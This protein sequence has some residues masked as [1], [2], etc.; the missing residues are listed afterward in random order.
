[1]KTF[2]RWAFATDLILVDP[3]TKLK[4]LPSEHN[5]VQPLTQDEMSRLVAATA[6]CGFNPEVAYKGEDVHPASAVVGLSVHGCR[7]TYA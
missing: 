6:E 3:S 2:F 1:V 4:S 7:H 5:Q